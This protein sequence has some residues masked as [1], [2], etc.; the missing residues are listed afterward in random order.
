MPNIV[1]ILLYVGSASSSQIENLTASARAILGAEI[2]LKKIRNAEL[3]AANTKTMT[4][5]SELASD[6]SVDSIRQMYG[7]LRENQRLHIP[8]HWRNERVWIG[9]LSDSPVGAGF[10]ARTAAECPR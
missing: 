8:G 4:A 5:E 9:T 2:G 10:V 3:I 1:P 7:V 6:I